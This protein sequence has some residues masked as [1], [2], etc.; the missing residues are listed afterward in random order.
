VARGRGKITAMGFQF[1]VKTKQ[2]ADRIVCLEVAGELDQ[3][4]AP[5]LG[6]AL[7][8]AIG[9]GDAGI[10]V[11]LTNCEFIDSTGLGLLVDARER[12]ISTDGRLFAICC[13]NDQVRRLL[14]ITGVGDAIGVVGTREDALASLRAGA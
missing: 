4:T 6:R 11:D 7:D 5:D 10:L 3:A 8:G 13:P 9:N 14:E 2:E 1:T 12:T